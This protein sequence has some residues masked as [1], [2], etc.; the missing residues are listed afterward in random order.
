MITNVSKS[1]DE[2]DYNVIAT[3]ACPT[4]GQGYGN[5]ISIDQAPTTANADLNGLAAALP[6]NQ[7]IEVCGTTGV[8]LQANNPAIGTGAWSQIAGPGTSTFSPAN[9]QPGNNN[10]NVTISGYSAPS[11]VT[12]RWTISNGVCPPSESDVRVLFDPKITVSTILAG[13]SFVPLPPF[14]NDSIM[15]LVTG[16]GGT[17]TLTYSH[18]NSDELRIDVSGS[19]K[20]YTAP[21]DGNAHNY[22]VSDAFCSES[23]SVTTPATKI[24]DIPLASAP[25]GTTT[26]NCYDKNFNKW[27]T[28]R[29][30]NNDAILA[31][32]DNDQDLGE[33]NVTV[34]KDN[35]EPSILTTVG[36]TCQNYPNTAM[37]RHFV[38]TAA[39]S[40]AAPVS[41]RLYFSEAELQSLKTASL[42]NDIAND[43]CS[44]NDNVNTVNDLYVTKY[45][46]SN[47]DGDYSNNDANGIYRV[48]GSSSVGPQQPDGP[49][50][51]GAFSALYDGGQSHHYVEMDVTEFSEM[52]LHGS[53][54]GSPL[55]VEMLYIEANA[56]DN[57]Y[58]EVKW[59]TALEINNSGFQVERST[60]GQNWAT[61][62]WVDGHNNSTTQQDY[63]YSDY[64]VA[65]NVRYYYRL[66]QVDNDGEYEYT[67]IVSAIINSQ[68]TFS[69]K[70]FIPNPAG[71]ITRLIITAT[72]EQTIGV[73]IYNAIGQKVISETHHLNKGGNELPFDLT[74]IA[75]GSYTAVVSSAN[76]VY[77]KKLIVVK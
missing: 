63:R 35:T 59:A 66:K 7:V 11:P 22:T 20:V 39:N 61:I 17:G 70:D 64:S 77:S 1:Q 45:T 28:F 41:V 62:G 47:E 16:S 38:V 36:S 12:Y 68:M 24:T 76:E 18:P 55:P 75:A 6:D 60:D 34:Y 44:K 65:A 3:N 49:L 27:L 58:I 8:T 46:G 10:N 13:C 57:S 14:S 42:A 71:N 23:G 74:N 52:W 25:S 30:N 5:I 48:F 69:V 9:G 53:Q 31:I 19:N 33:V 15:I 37:R 32:N 29:D 21:T 26:A 54:N 2:G 72:S 43:A 56:I 4:Q 51:R 67:G 50:A 73:D 40:F